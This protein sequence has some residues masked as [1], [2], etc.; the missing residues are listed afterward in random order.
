M[1]QNICQKD[2]LD[3]LVNDNIPSLSLFLS[4]VVRGRWDDIY[5]IKLTPDHELH[6]EITI[7]P[8][9]GILDWN[10]VMEGISFVVKEAMDKGWEHITESDGDKLVISFA[11]RFELK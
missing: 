5:N 10:K 9:S 11:K 7:D 6:V 1:A 2:Y 3:K 8:V 4:E